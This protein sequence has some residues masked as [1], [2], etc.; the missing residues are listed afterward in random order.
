MPNTFLK[1]SVI[2]KAALG[3]L[4]RE[5]TLPRLVWRDAV[6]DFAGALDDTISIRVPAFAPARTRALRSGAART[7]D[8]IT[9]RKVDVTLTTDVYKDIRITDEQLSLDI[10]DFGSQVLNPAVQG[11]VQALEDV[12]V[13]KM[14]EPTYHTTI[15]F[16]TATD[17]AWDDLIIP[18]R[19]ALNKANVPMNERG[20]AVGAELESALLRT[21]LFVKANESGSRDALED[22]TIGRKAGFQV[23]SAPGLGPLEG[24]AFHKTAYVMNE[25]APKVPQSAAFGASES[26]QGFAMRVVKVL[27]PDTIEEI[28]ALDAWV[29]ANYVTDDGYFDSNGLFIPSSEVIGASIALANPSAAADD[30]IDTVAAHGLAAGDV[31]TPTALTGGAGLVVGQRYY[32][33]AANLAATTFQVSL[34]EGGAAVDFTTNITAGS[35]KKN[36]AAQ[37]VRAVK[38]AGS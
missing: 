16:N 23:V 21:D 6:P 9:E 34:T 14:Q 28:L 32:V 27:D 5:I 8:S 11:V 18:A 38:I 4:V 12:L 25:R 37:M 24:Y 2:V 13:A 19:E 10:S 30:I 1:P 35:F 20:L 36:G 22:A 17:D 3:L 15:A 26:Y 7:R 29:G 31:V 33:I